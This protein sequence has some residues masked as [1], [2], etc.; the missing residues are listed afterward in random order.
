MKTENKE[1]LIRKGVQALDD[2]QVTLD[3][4]IA[5]LKNP[6]LQ[7][8]IHAYAELEEIKKYRVRAEEKIN[9]LRESL[10]PPAQLVKA[11]KV[12]RSDIIEKIIL[13]LIK[14]D[15][16]KPD[17][18]ARQD[19]KKILEMGKLD[20]LRQLHVNLSDKYEEV[21]IE[22]AKRPNLN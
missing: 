7:F 6:L 19:F 22:K 5:T 12:L 3:R 10:Q 20:T 11:G 15:K 14:L 4:E 18:Q 13:L 17:L 8:I 1:D 16:I 2:I 21:K 9:R